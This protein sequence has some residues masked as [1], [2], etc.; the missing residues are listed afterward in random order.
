MQ[1]MQGLLNVTEA[2]LRASEIMEGQPQANR[3]ALPRHWNVCMT[4]FSMIAMH[5]HVHMPLPFNLSIARPR[6]GFV[7]AT[8]GIL[9]VHPVHHMHDSCFQLKQL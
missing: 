6:P 9:T 1:Y 4:P 5:Q 8:I 2:V 3:S 7:D